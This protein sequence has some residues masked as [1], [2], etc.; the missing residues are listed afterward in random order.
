[1]QPHDAKSY[2]TMAL[3]C[4][5]GSFCWVKVEIYDIVERPYS[6]L[7]RVAQFFVIQVAIF[8]EM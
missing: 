2:R 6:N 5:P 1:L 4:S 7:D 8:V 3:V